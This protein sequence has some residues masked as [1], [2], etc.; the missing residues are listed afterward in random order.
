ME[1]HIRQSGLGERR[2]E[3]AG[4]ADPVGEERGA[5]ALLRNAPDDPDEVLA[6]SQRR[7]TARDLDVRMLAVMGLY[8]VDA[9]KQFF[10]GDVPDR[11]G[12]LR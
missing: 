6:P 2:Q 8:H 4:R 7:L 5:H 3:L 10:Q 11:L 1:G 12:V 9:A